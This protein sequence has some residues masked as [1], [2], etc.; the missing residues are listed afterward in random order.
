MLWLLERNAERHWLLALITYVP[1]HW[2]L[3]P[4]LLLV[5]GATRKHNRQA[6]A[7][8][9]ISLGVIAFVFLGV[10]VPFRRLVAPP[11]AQGT[12]LRVVSYNVKLSKK[13]TSAVAKAIENLNADVVCAQEV[14]WLPSE[15]AAVAPL[16][17]ALPD[18]HAQH[19]GELLT[20]SRT[21]ILSSKVHRMG[22]S[23]AVSCQ[24][25]VINVR[26]NRIHF[27]NTHI[28]YPGSPSRDIGAQIE[29]SMPMRAAQT[30]GV[31][32]A[33]QIS[34]PSIIMGDFN[35]P[36]RGQIYAAFRTHWRDTFRDAGWGSGNSFPVGLPLIRI[37]YV[38]TSRDFQ[39]QRCFVANENAS[40]HYPLVADLVLR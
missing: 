16:L 11:T 14:P 36:P 22:K 40:D 35:T 20:L 18:W 37:D 13:S 17:R 1:Q 28:V 3:V 30:R 9:S 7:V 23:G 27:F 31:I 25:T 12:R 33:A 34:S 15:N 38:W 10:N 4:W 5:Y 21:P 19:D 2:L 39:A 24:E 8:H 6:L 29:R 26:G 32:R